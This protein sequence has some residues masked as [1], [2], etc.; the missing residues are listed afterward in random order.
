MSNDGDK[1]AEPFDEDDVYGPDDDDDDP[2][3][4]SQL[5]AWFG[6][7]SGA[8]TVAIEAEQNIAELQ[9]IDPSVAGTSREP[10]IPEFLRKARRRRELA[11]EAVDAGFLSDLERRLEEHSQFVTG[12]IP[13]EPVLDPG[14][15]RFDAS[16]ADSAIDLDV[17]Q[18]QAGPAIAEALEHNTPQA[19]LRDLHRI[20]SYPPE[21]R[22]DLMPLQVP[23]VGARAATVDEAMEQRYTI[24]MREY[25][26]ARNYIAE[27]FP[28]L[29]GRIWAEPWRELEPEERVGDSAASLALEAMMWFG[30]SV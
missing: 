20:V 8:H 23:R 15:A 24:F 11:L 14:V 22:M 25:P 9:D 26:L 27:D 5:Q 13:P 18:R 28:E 17:S 10:G 29:R 7:A 16:M 30:G 21:I 1:S 6:G 19:L 2:A 3:L 12:P 4:L